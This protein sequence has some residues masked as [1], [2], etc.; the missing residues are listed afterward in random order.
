MK[1]ALPAVL[2]AL[3]AVPSSGLPQGKPDF[4]GTWIMDASRSESP[5]QNE[6]VKSM[7]V[8][9]GQ[10]PYEISIQTTRDERVQRIT[11]R[12]GGPEAL[13]GGTGRG[14]LVASI[15]YWQGDR[16]V[17]ETLNDV[18]GMTVRTKAV[19]TLQSGSA[20]LSIE[21]LLVVEHGYTMRGGKNYGSVTDIFK[22]SAP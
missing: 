15:W 4:S 14:S 10:T 12:P 1:H 20:E 19:H 7:T 2:V 8:V 5:V 18:N 3:L 16:L 13:G 21:S 17:T 9:I 22:K 6:P 11:Y